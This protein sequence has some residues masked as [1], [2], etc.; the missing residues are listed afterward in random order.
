MKQVWAGG[1]GPST[2]PSRCGVSRPAKA[3][4]SVPRDSPWDTVE[5]DTSGFR[6][7]GAGPSGSRASRA[8]GPFVARAA[9][10]LSGQVRLPFAARQVATDE[11]A[12]ASAQRVV[13]RPRLDVPQEHAP[14]VPRGDQSIAVGRERDGV[15]RAL[16]PGERLAD[17][18]T[19]RDVEENDRPL[20]RPRGD[21]PS[22]RTEAHGR[23]VGVGLQRLARGLALS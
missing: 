23:Q 3:A 10:G 17:L 21:E 8:G 12:G 15:D 14:V 16:V 1:L 22:V 19:A 7:W 6:R 13:A 18:L 20:R 2:S 5:T 4:R 9:V 11:I